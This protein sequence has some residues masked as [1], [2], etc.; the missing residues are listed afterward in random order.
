MHGVRDG[1]VVDGVEQGLYP[2]STGLWGRRH[3]IRGGVGAT[4]LPGRT[5]QGGPDSGHEVGVR[6]AGDE[7]HTGQATGGQVA[8]KPSQPAPSSAPV[9]CKPSISL[10]PSLIHARRK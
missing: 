7:F 6:V 4:T 9:T 10:C 8:E 5:G 2:Q 1:L 3:E